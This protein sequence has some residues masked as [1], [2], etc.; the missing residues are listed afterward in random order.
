MKIAIFSGRFSPPHLGHIVTIKNLFY[1]YD[2]VIV[3]ILDYPERIG[4]SANVAQELFKKVFYTNKSQLENVVFVQNDKHFG[5]ITKLQLKMLLVNTGELFDEM[6]YVGGN[7]EVNKHI[8]S[9]KVI[10]VEYIPRTIIY[11]STSL[12]K[13]IKEGVSLEDQ[14]R[15]KI[16]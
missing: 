2:K 11:N 7:K 4:C 6:V 15:I 14:Y 12:R 9:L 3:V 1:K 13:K 10:P 5:R 8:E 16:K